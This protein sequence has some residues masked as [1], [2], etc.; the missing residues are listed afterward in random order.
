VEA[1][2]MLVVIGCFHLPEA[3]TRAF[4]RSAALFCSGVCGKIAERYCVP[5]S[6]PWRFSVV[7]SS[8]L[9]PA[10]GVADVGVDHPGH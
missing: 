9:K 7:G 10:A 5:T 8:S 4:T 3:S 1:G 6:L 2:S